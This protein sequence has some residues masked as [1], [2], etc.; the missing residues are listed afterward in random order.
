MGS[1]WCPWDCRWQRVNAIVAGGLGRGQQREQIMK[2]ICPHP[3]QLSF[4]GPLLP[5]TKATFSSWLLYVSRLVLK[6]FHLIHLLR[7]VSHS[8]LAEMSSLFLWPS[9]LKELVCKLSKVL[10]LV[11]RL[12]INLPMCLACSALWIT[13]CIHRTHSPRRPWCR[14]IGKIGIINKAVAPE[15]RSQSGYGETAWECCTK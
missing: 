11:T 6:H 12:S 9:L 5:A 4:A 3:S 15:I 1:P 7:I 10:C 13:L 2:H 8:E 14:R